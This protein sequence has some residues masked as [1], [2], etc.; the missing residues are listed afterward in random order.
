MP[1]GECAATPDAGVAPD[2][3]AD[4]GAPDAAPPPPDAGARDAA[5]ADLGQVSDDAHAAPDAT[6]PSPDAEA[7]PDAEPPRDAEPAGDAGTIAD[8][9]ALAD[10]A[11][12]GDAGRGEAPTIVA[13]TPS[14][15]ANVAA[16]PIVVTGSGFVDGATLRIGAIPAT[17][18]RVPGATTLLANVPPNIAPG[19]YDVVLQNPDGQAAV[20]TKGFEVTGPGTDASSNC[21]ATAAPTW[22]AIAALLVLRRRRRG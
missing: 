18:I 15:G 9:D 22:A 21:Q 2:A 3:A 20:L 16:T 19:A 6:P 5:P 14:R 8:A 12:A 1:G 13:L 11:P 17:E 7:T 4:A 10:A